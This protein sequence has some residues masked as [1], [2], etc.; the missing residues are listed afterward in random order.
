M[1][2][3]N[4]DH[5]G[6]ITEWQVSLYPQGDVTD[7]LGHVSVYLTYLSGETMMLLWTMSL[8]NSPTSQ[9]RP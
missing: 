4:R 9:V 6:K 2:I 8:S 7:A 1:G 3:I 5:D